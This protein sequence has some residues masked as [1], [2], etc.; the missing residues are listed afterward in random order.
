MVGLGF[1]EPSPGSLKHVKLAPCPDVVE[2][3]V[4]PHLQQL[5]MT[6]SQL[7]T[8]PNQKHW[9]NS[10]SSAIVS[11]ISALKLRP[12]CGCCPEETGIQTGSLGTEF[13][14]GSI[15]EGRNCLW[16]RGIKVIIKKVLTSIRSEGQVPNDSKSQVIKVVI[17]DIY[18]LH[19]ICKKL[20]S[21]HASSQF[22]R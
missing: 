7:G 14:Q 2:L 21:S 12:R 13:P 8:L 20:S 10:Y 17:A 19:G 15:V 9:V 5:D 3:Q 22:L 18:C 11:L 16:L 4:N 6:E 1:L